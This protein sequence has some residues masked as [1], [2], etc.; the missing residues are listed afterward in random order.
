MRERLNP[1]GYTW[2][3]YLWVGWWRLGLVAGLIAVDWRGTNREAF[4]YLAIMLAIIFLNIGWDSFGR[5]VWQ[6]WR[7]K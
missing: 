6:G 5:H 2:Q 7:S 4:W 3:K 1:R